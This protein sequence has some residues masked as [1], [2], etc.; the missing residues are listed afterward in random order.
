M[1]V[2]I[3]PETRR[4]MAEFRDVNWA[5]VIREAVARRVEI[6]E[7]LR[8]PIDRRR[9]LRAARRMDALRNSLP[10]SDT[11]STEEIRRWRDLRR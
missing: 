5:E 3:D 10:R 7:S 4:K 11:D 1:S 8:V 6:E 2:R 9:A